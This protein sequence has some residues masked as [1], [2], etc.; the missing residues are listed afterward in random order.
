MEI[1]FRVWYDIVDY[2]FSEKDFIMTEANN[3][4][5]FYLSSILL[6]ALT[7]ILGR[8][9]SACH[10][11]T[12]TD[13]AYADW[14]PGLLGWISELI[15]AVR[16]AAGFAAIAAAVFFADKKCTGNVVLIASAAAFLDYAAR[17]VIDLLSS[18]LIGTELLAAV[19]LLLQFVYEVIFIV[20]S[21]IVCG[22]FK[23][24]FD[25][26]E[27]EF[28]KRKYSGIR[29]VRL[30]ILL[31]TASRVAL[32]IYYLVDF[33]L[34]YA[35]VTNAE[36]A[37]IIGQFLKCIV[38]YGGIPLL[39]NELVYPVFAIFAGNKAETEE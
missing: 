6:L 37:S 4:R 12:A 18:A 21:W 11:I 34:A 26:S 17:F 39:V 36:V 1:I 5:K 29:A 20:L 3:K 16:T 28:S 25:A 33:L 31:L 24:K 23:K 27:T 38:I 15:P 10:S 14:V 7:V 35:D 2:I 9:V 32:E 19:W 22:I 8:I 30:S 13:I